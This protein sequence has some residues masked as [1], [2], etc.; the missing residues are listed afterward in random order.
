[1]WNEARARI[2]MHLVAK[3]PV[4]FT[5]CGQSF[6]MAEGEAIHTENSHKY[7]SNSANLLLLAGGWEPLAHY[8][9]PNALF[10]VVL[11]RAISAEMTA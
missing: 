1:V 7:S 2:E 10:M 8:V 5:I 6:T 3:R 9:D 4:S 11:A